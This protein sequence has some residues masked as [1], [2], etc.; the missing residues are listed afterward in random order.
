MDLNEDLI[1]WLSTMQIALIHNNLNRE[2]LI[3]R[4]HGERFSITLNCADERVFPAREYAKNLAFSSLAALLLGTNF[5]GQRDLDSIPGQGG[6]EET[7]GDEH[8]CFHSLNCDKPQ[9]LSGHLD[10]SLNKLRKFQMTEPSAFDPSDTFFLFQ[11]L[12][13]RLQGFSLG[14]SFQGQS[15]CQFHDHERVVRI[16]GEECQNAGF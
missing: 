1:A 6:P 2:F 12:K 4:Y 13:R 10:L 11:F 8:V 9:S 7:G 5:R 14:V 16:P 15:S 3:I